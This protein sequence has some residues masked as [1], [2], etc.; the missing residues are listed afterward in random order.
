MTILIE[1]LASMKNSFFISITFLLICNSAYSQRPDTAATSTDSNVIP[2][3]L[4]LVAGGTAGLIVTAHLQNYNSWWKG[5]R[6]PFHLSVDDSPTLGADKCGHFLFSYYAADIVGNSL[7]W[8]GIGRDRGLLYGGIVSI[9]FQLY[10]EVEDG[11]HPDLGFSVG[12]AV[13]DG[14]GAILPL[15]QEKYHSF[16]AISP[17]WSINP[18]DRYKQHQYRSIIDD[19]ESQYYWLSFNLHELLGESSPKFIPSFLNVALGYGVS[20]LD[21]H[22]NGN[23]EMYLALDIDFT[24]LPG[25]GDILKAVKHVLNFFHVPA[26][27]IRLTPSIIVYGLR[28]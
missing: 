11:F 8:S 5:T 4:G 10:V 12:D 16:R 24:K 22:G 28:F 13:A 20:D 27:T 26:P 19:Y 9:A 3:R 2:W 21:L 17:K 6:G 15:L 23:S 18:S 7:D 25:D 14:A 1:D